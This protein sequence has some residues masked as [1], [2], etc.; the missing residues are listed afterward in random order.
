MINNIKKLVNLYVNSFR[1]ICF[2]SWTIL[3]TIF[4]NSMGQMFLLFLTLYL[5]SYNFSL[6][7]ISYIVSGYSIG[8]L[9]GSYFG[10]ELV[11]KLGIK[12]LMASLLISGLLLIFIIICELFLIKIVCIIFLGMTH[13][14]FKPASIYMLLHY[15]KPHDKQRLLGFRRVMVNLGMSVAT[16]LGGY[17]SAFN[18]NYVFLCESIISLL[19][20]LML[21]FTYLKNKKIFVLNDTYENVDTQNNSAVS[22]STWGLYIILFF[23]MLVFAQLF[24]T[25]PLYL[26]AYYKINSVMFAKLFTINTVIILLIEVPLLNYIKNTEQSRLLMLGTLLM[27]NGLAI[28]PL[29]DNLLFAYFSVILWTLGEIIFFP[30]ILNLIL[31]S[32]HGKK[33]RKIGFYQLIHSLGM[34]IGPTIGVSLY[35]MYNGSLVWITCFI[36]SVISCMLLL[37]P[38]LIF[39]GEPSS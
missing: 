7:T 9:L 37:R 19:A 16:I 30:S 3:V 39:K 22:P 18:Y 17:L 1:G 27:C 38:R 13:N 26:N 33:G 25:Y 28:L 23:N 29:S 32:S 34:L 35:R 14:I 21:F 15:A 4:I 10:G 12:T 36:I 5:H 24:V 2:L 11:E 6:T 8:S 31:Y 20:F